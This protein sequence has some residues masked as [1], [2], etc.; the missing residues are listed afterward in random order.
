MKCIAKDGNYGVSNC[1]FISSYLHKF[2]YNSNI[3]VDDSFILE[4]VN[5]S[6]NDIDEF[7]FETRRKRVILYFLNEIRR[8]EMVDIPKFALEVMKILFN[9]HDVF[10]HHQTFKNIIHHKPTQYTTK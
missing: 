10:Y 3:L 2:V 5:G 8:F 1:C 7:L 6:S 4:L 9:E